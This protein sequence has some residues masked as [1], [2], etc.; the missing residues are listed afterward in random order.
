MFL[1]FNGRLPSRQPC[2]MDLAACCVG[3]IDINVTNGG[4][5]IRWPR[6]RLGLMSQSLCSHSARCIF[7]LFIHLFFQPPDGCCFLTAARHLDIAVRLFQFGRWW[8][9]G[10]VGGGEWGGHL[11]RTASSENTQ[12]EVEMEQ[13]SILHI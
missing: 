10:M 6:G 9:W 2:I 13:S 7:I 8:W 3:I 1:H 11:Q 5:C 12:R 4:G